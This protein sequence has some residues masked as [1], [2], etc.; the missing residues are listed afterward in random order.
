[1]CITVR[2]PTS[3]SSPPTMA[4]GKMHGRTAVRFRSAVRR[5]RRFEGGFRVP[6]IMWWPGHIPAGAHYGEMMSHIVVRRK[7]WR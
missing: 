7:A 4:R 3:S 1:M 5:V 2:R 6:G